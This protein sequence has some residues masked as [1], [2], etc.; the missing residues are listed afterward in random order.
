MTLKFSMKS[1]R[2]INETYNNISQSKNIRAQ[3]FSTPTLMLIKK[4]IEQNVF[5]EMQL[6]HKMKESQS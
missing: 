4:L 1:S 6:L 2:I 5:K 3:T